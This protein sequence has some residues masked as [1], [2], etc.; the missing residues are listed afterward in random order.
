MLDTLLEFLGLRG[1]AEAY[2]SV[3]A[4]EADEELAALAKQIK[5]LPYLSRLYLKEREA[6]YGD[7]K[8]KALIKKAEGMGYG[9]PSNSRGACTGAV[10]R[11]SACW[12]R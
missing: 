11:W 6:L 2:T 10:L 8:S 4:S 3:P 1:K 9:T 12:Q 5:H 7:R